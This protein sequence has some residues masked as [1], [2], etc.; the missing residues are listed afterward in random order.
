LTTALHC[1]HKELSKTLQPGGVTDQWPSVLV[2]D[3]M[4]TMRCCQGYTFPKTLYTGGIQTRDRLFWRRTRWPPCHAA[5]A[6]V[7]RWKKVSRHPNWPYI[8]ESYLL[9]QCILINTNYLLRCPLLLYI[10]RIFCF[11]RWFSKK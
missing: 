11:F 4:T 1:I 9:N 8:I 2:A 6:K 7:H 3:V 10:D 5:R